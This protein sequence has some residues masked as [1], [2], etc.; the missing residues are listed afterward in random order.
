[1]STQLSLSITFLDDRFHGQGNNGPEWPPSP[2]RIYQAMLCA[3]ARNAC[4][5]DDEFCW[6]ESLDPPAVI[7]PQ[8]T[9]AQ[10]LEIFVPNNDA[11]VSKK[12][13]RQ[14]RLTSKVMRPS[15]ILG[16]SK[17][18]EYI[19]TIEPQDKKMAEKIIHRARLIS[20]VGWG[21]DLVVADGRI[22]EDEN[23]SG[24]GDVQ[25]WLPVPHSANYGENILRCPVIGTLA[26][27]RY[28]YDSFL[29]RI[30]GKYYQA[31]PRPG[32]FRE[33]AYRI[34]GDTT[35]KRPLT[36]FKLVRP[37]DDSERYASFDPRRA[38]HVAAWVRGLACRLS[39]ASEQGFVE[40][41][42]PEQYVA[43]HVP[44]NIKEGPSP[45]RFSYLPIPT[46]GHKHADGR[47]RRFIIAE[48]YGS[49]GDC[50]RWARETLSLKTLVDNDDRKQAQLSHIARDEMIAHYTR[51]SNTFET[52]TPVVLSGHNDRSYSKTQ[53]LLLR[54]IEHAGFELD[55][56]EDIY[57]QKAPFFSGAFHPRDYR[58]PAYLKQNPHSSIHARIT[59]R[60]PICGP[61]AI[62]AGRYFGLGL[63][64]PKNDT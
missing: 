54:A 11:D 39:T 45:S 42:D 60:R 24:N 22:V 43:G 28:V 1:M 34:K 27:L 50:L 2:H 9:A 21:I 61:L 48:P 37:D 55:D 63:F 47:I 44:K 57:L 25:H 32:I 31:P 19:W 30:D 58:L 33:V 36:A 41:I 51:K 8:A 35:P 59:W 23:P 40:G 56:I 10:R 4:D 14:N 38:M 13:D 6:F 53:K 12:F 52:V 20:A 7:A 29:N 46:I 62:G 49:R 26:D 5:G 18:V 15:R 17:T 16:N 3:A 64:T